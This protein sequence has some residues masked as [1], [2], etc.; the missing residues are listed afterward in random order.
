MART[1]TSEGG[2]HDVSS[3]SKLALHDLAAPAAKRAPDVAGVS[4]VTKFTLGNGVRVL[5]KQRPDVPLVSMLTTFPGGARFEPV[6]KSGV[7]MLTHRVL[8][9]G[10]ARYSAE[11]IA[12]RIEGLG[13]GIDSY[14]SFDSGGVAMGVLSEYAED[15]V[16]IYRDVLRAPKFDPARVDQERARLLE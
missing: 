2:V 14:S 11:E 9:K 6:G 4:G 10:S 7:G 16:E 15:A 5:L 12:A 13:G 1:L 8:T 3:A